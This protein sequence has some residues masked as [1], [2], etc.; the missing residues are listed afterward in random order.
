MGEPIPSP[1][2]WPI[3]GNV[4]DLDAEFPM[5]SLSNLAQRYGEIFKLTL[6]GHERVFICQRDLFNELMDEKR[7]ENAVTGALVHIRDVVHDGLFTA[8]P[9]EHNWGVAH[10]ALMPAFGP[11]PVHGMFDEMYDIATQL[12]LKWDRY[13]PQHDIKVTDDF[14]RLTLDSI[15]LCAMGTRF[16]SFYTEEMH[17][18][19][20]AMVGVLIGAGERA[21]RPP[22]PSYFYRAADQKFQDNVDLLL[23][24]STDL[25]KQRRE[26]PTDKNDLLNAMLHNKD[27][28][29]GEHLSEESIAYNMITFLIAGHETTSGL[30]SFVFYELLKNPEAYR[31]AQEEVDQVLGDNTITVQHIS[32]LE[33]LNAI[34]RETLRLHP[35][36]PAFTVHAK[37]DEILGGK[38]HVTKDTA[39]V[40][41]LMAIH[42]DHA[43]YGE[44]AEAFRPERMLDEPFGKLPP[45]AWKPFGNGSR[46]CIGRPFAWQE[47][48]LSLAMLLQVFDFTMTD[49]SY[50]LVIQSTL[51]I[52]PHGFFMRAKPRY[53][54]IASRLRGQPA[55]TP[56]TEKTST[57]TKGDSNSN[58]PVLSVFYGSNTGTCEAMANSL[59]S[60]ASSHGFQAKIDILDKATNAL[61][62]EGPVVIITSSYEGE[63]PDNAAQFVSWLKSLQGESAKGVKYAVFGCGNRDWR[64]TYHK[65]PT[66]VDST[67][68]ERG[69]ERMVARGAA[70][71]NDAGFLDEYD[72]W[73]DEELWPAI[74][75]A[76]QIQATKN[77]A[78]PSSGLDVQ[79]SADSRASFLRQDLK[80]AMVL[81]TR[82]LTPPGGPEKRH[83]EI[84][85]PSG[86]PYRAGDYLA[87]LPFNPR[88]NVRRALARFNLAYDAMITISPESHTT[89]PQGRS[90][91]VFDVFSALV[92]LAQPATSKQLKQVAET[93]PESELKEGLERHATDDFKSEVL[94]RNKSLLDILEEYPSATFTLGQ[95]LEALPPMRIRQYSISSSPLEDPSKCTITYSVIDAPIRGGNPD[96]DRFL[97][98]C[99]NYLRSREV[100][101]RINVAVRPSH[102]GFHLPLDDNTPVLMVCA[103]TGLAPFRAFVQ[104]RALQI[105]SGRKLAPA[106]L[107]Y[108]CGAPD[109]DAIYLSEIAEW[110]AQGAVE[111][112]HAFS[113]ASEQSFGCRHVQDRIWHDRE[114]AKALFAK[115][116]QVYMCGASVVGIEITKVMTDM[117]MGVKKVS[118]EDAESWVTQLKGV[119]Y[120]ADV[121]A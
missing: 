35:P 76:F 10:R 69:A 1:R 12:V 79:V 84:Q 116:A 50:Q 59:A 104:E 86:M 4:L 30:L 39:L 89:L 36:A 93:I 34:L 20:N 2:A 31:K 48:L 100:G 41:F 105:K 22:V 23:K 118:R 14:T 44:D 70:D 52:K 54:D 82:L 6:G 38:Y 56:K 27:P 66:L 71:A 25:V 53:P 46:A 45:N 74:A 120:W 112:R 67:L 92:E 113:R 88:R 108:G 110:Q 43:V 111:V 47:A 106:L 40:C 85:L 29:T 16:N 33:Y 60:S 73:K 11:L 75:K 119:R 62:K 87:V 8:L 121:F 107:F 117:Y 83:M 49:P 115:N 21:R 9:G 95:F 65:I 97:G 55:S 26:N 101:D 80:T 37:Q 61:A 96:K 19:V 5:T 94:G 114:D 99:S 58:L 57:P 81:E 28:K 77:E 51:T 103:G 13:G 17:P 63:P 64:H 15:A 68:A 18:F 42:K 24:V 78:T 3:I 7:F 32:K 109:R 91:P 90:L 102:A 98:V 72:K